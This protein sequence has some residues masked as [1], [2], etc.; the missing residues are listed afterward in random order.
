MS[1]N[2]KLNGVLVKTPSSL[3]ISYQDIDTDGTFR[4]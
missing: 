1:A 2:F 4:S 3:Q